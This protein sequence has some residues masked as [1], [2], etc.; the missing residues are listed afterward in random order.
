M[1]DLYKKL[2][3]T[4]DHN[5]DSY[6]TPALIRIRIGIPVDTFT[7]FYATVPHMCNCHG[8]MYVINHAEIRES[9]LVAGGSDDLVAAITQH[10]VDDGVVII[11]DI[12]IWFLDTKF[13]Y[14]NLDTVD[15]VADVYVA[16]QEE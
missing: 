4:L 10:E 16:R 2:L 14:E 9:D 13:L 1:A 15:R 7:R 11:S 12:T 6:F 8:A 5:I 3:K